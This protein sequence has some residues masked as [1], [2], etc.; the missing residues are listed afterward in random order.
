MTL[1]LTNKVGTGPSLWHH[2]PEALS[3]K[4]QNFL[5]PPRP[6]NSFSSHRATMLS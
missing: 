1:D 6:E 2:Q 3:S 4:W 5:L